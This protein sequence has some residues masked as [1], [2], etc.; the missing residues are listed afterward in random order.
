MQSET[1]STHSTDV[2][3]VIAT[4]T[5]DDPLIAFLR[6]RPKSRSLA[7]R[8]M[9]AL[10]I[11]F[12][13]HAHYPSDEMWV[14]L[15]AVAETLQAMADGDADPLIY[16][17]SLD[18]GV[19]KT[20]TY[21]HFIRE[22]LEHPDYDGVAVI[23]CI[24]RKD[25][26]RAVVDEAK[27]QPD[28]FAVLTADAELNAL[29]SGNPNSARVLFT[30][31][32]MV[33]SRCQHGTKAFEDVAAFHYRGKPRAVRIWDEAI[34]PGQTLT[35]SR[36]DVGLLFKPLRFSHPNLTAALEQLFI[37][38][39]T[40]PDGEIIT[41]PNFAEDHGVTLNDVMGLVEHST[42][43]TKAAVECLWFLSGRTV[44]VRQDGAYGNTVLDY[45]DTLP[46][47]IKPLIV[48]DASIRVRSIYDLWEGG[49]GGVVRLPD[50]E[51]RYSEL[52]LHVWRHGGGKSAFRRNGPKLIEGIASTILIKPGEEWLV[53][54]HKDAGLDFERQLSQI[55]P[56]DVTPR[57]R[58]LT[59]GSHDATNA[60]AHVPNVIL[61]GILFY[62][63]SHYEALGRLAAGKSS[64]AGP[65]PQ[66]ETQRVMD[67]ENRHLI[68]Q[69]AC[70]G[71]VRK[72]NGDECLPSHVYIIASRRTNI[73]RDL[74][75]VFP[76]AR[77]VRWRPVEKA[78]TGKIGE[79]YAYIVERLRQDP[80]AIVAF[81]DTMRAI[82]W[83]D[84]KE[85]KKRIREHD[86]FIDALVAEGIEE[87]G[88]GIRPTGFR[89]VTDLPA[90]E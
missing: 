33:E 60:F 85:F 8:T 6:N 70:R 44:T 7:G 36:D 76:G 67:G 79:A 49:R 50:A 71:A 63:G 27:L 42:E 26:I 2:A 56:D 15:R 82:G 80:R 21:I 43:S 58:F 47:D 51:K 41:L 24:S 30:T 55:L 52:T 64:A 3:P 35:V 11:T 54:H 89:R 31:Q 83:K 69:A 40:L 37:H 88:K 72:S 61:A 12:L 48:L 23:V 28:D 59:W 77:I 74:P 1:L 66:S 32:R 22:M 4:Q 53:V 9:D 75:R 87:Y 25:Q 78:L 81:R 57:V 68:L 20:Q 17:S 18:P 62:R 5:G 65:F 29:G 46:D 13:K 19:G 90:T 38:L 10:A 34:L 14:A 45:K 73:E 84:A 86:D 39:G 16:L